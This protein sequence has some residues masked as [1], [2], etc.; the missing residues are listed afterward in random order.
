MQFQ[1]IFYHKVWYDEDTGEYYTRNELKDLP[2]ERVSKLKEVFSSLYGDVVLVK[3]PTHGKWHPLG[4][5]LSRKEPYYQVKA[6]G[7]GHSNF[8]DVMLDFAYD[9]EEYIK[10]VAIYSISRAIA[11]R[12]VEGYT[13]RLPQ[14]AKKVVKRFLESGEYENAKK[15]VESLYDYVKFKKFDDETIEKIEALYLLLLRG[16]VDGDE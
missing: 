9:C 8:Y 6:G 2:K 10:L 14:V 4:E 3:C 11:S 7:K 5:N 15:L 16:D 1:R 12:I 13:N